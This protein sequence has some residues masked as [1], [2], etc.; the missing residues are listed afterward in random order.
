MKLILIK[1]GKALNV[2]QREGTISGGKRVVKTFLEMLSWFSVKPG[3]IL[4][5]SGGVGDSAL[6]RACHCAE[7]LEIHGFKCSVTI[8]DNP[9]LSRYAGR[10]KIFI[11][12]RVLYTSN[13][14]ELIKEIKKQKKEIIFGTDDLIF[15]PKY[16]EY[17]DYYKKMNSFEKKLYE[18]GVGGEILNDSYVK[19]CT[20]TASFLAEKLKEKN[21]KVLIVPNKL[22]NKDLKIVDKILKSKKLSNGSKIKIGYFSGTMSHNK[23]FAVITPVITKI[24]ERYKNVELFLVGPLDIESELNKFKNRLVQLAYVPRNKHFENVAKVDINLAP[25]E[26]GNPFC[27]SKSELKF[28]EAG[29]LKVPTVA[30]ATQT[31]KEAIDDGIDGF[32]AGN[33][34]EWIEKLERLIESKKLRKE[35]GEKAREKSLR[36]YTNKNSDNQDYYDYLKNKIR[37]IKC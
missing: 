26:I 8:Q 33:S 35:M 21:K 28:F 2:I 1:I 13:I 37:E 11:F 16:L 19:I 9:F 22:S 6:Y 29:I 31:F 14:A 32:T 17:M 5:I 27:E 10:F 24:M 12:H 3:D 30:S 20:T 36:K 34:E 25:L 4:F 15:D 7:E 23:D 18:N